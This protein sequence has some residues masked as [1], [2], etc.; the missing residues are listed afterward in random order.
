MSRAPHYLAYADGSCIGNPG[1]GGWGVVLIMPDGEHRE[2]NGYAASTTNNRMEIEAAV[3]AL[4]EIPEGAEVVVRSDS[5][6]V[7]RTIND[8][9]KRRKNFDS[10][11]ALDLEIAVQLAGEALL[12][13]L[14]AR[15]RPRVLSTVPRHVGTAREAEPALIGYRR[16]A[17][18]AVHA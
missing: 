10:W 3:R 6:Y 1:P 11:D 5:Q 15:D 4:R 7:V 2:L 17:A 18:V 12:E 9:W 16:C 14:I 13:L 8:G